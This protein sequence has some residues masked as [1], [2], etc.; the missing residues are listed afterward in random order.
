MLAEASPGMMV[1]GGWAGIKLNCFLFN[2]PLAPDSRA[3][4]AVRFAHCPCT[5]SVAAGS[6]LGLG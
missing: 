3:G 4:G 6:G 5:T 1:P 2:F